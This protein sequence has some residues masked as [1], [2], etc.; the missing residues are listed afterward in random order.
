MDVLDLAAGRRSA[1]GYFTDSTQQLDRLSMPLLMDPVGLV[2]LVVSLATP[3][4]CAM[5]VASIQTFIAVNENNLDDAAR[6]DLESTKGSTIRELIRRANKEFG[7]VGSKRG[8]LVVLLCAVS[9]TAT[10][11]LALRSWG[12]LRSWNPTSKSDEA[13]RQ[14]VYD[15]WWA[16]G[17]HRE[18]AVLLFGLGVFLFYFLFKQLWMGF[19]FARFA[20][21]TQLEGFGVTPNLV[22]DSDGY[23]GLRPLRWFMLVTYASSVAHFVLALG[24]L[25]IWL[26][27]TA[28]TMFLVVGLVCT[29]AIV[30]I[31]PSRIAYRGALEARRAR[32]RELARSAASSVEERQEQSNAISQLWA[33]PVLP[34]RTRS[35]LTAV[36]LYFLFPLL[37]A[38]VSALIK[39]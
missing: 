21:A 33:G 16:S 5:Q 24:V 8:S 17:D 2:V 36:T 22:Y 29:N 6:A 34:F 7:L 4:L 32:A 28:W 30:V 15:G 9:T 27:T 1:I 23:A 26:P 14:A 18:M 20:R 38:I 19:V 3:C 31:Y 35:S 10:A 39:D 37:L 25:A 11:Y 13:W 12:L